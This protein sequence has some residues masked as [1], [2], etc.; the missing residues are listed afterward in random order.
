MP[1]AVALTDSG[2]GTGR[3]RLPLAELR[4]GQCQCS[5][6]AATQAE[7]PV[8]LQCQ[9]QSRPGPGHGS[10]GPSATVPVTASLSAAGGITKLATRRNLKGRP[11]VV[12][13]PVR[14]VGGGSGAGDAVLAQQLPVL[15]QLANDWARDADDDEES[16]AQPLAAAATGGL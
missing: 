9:W 8:A 4:L 2:T 10:P 14:L 12:S 13:L 7:V 1:L 5:A 3:L 16:E 15:A 6:E 11:G